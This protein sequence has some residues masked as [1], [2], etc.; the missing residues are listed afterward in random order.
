[1]QL[2]AARQA[3][4]AVM[5]VYCHIG[6]VVLPGNDA[7]D[8]ED[9]DDGLPGGREEGDYRRTHVPAPRRAS[10]TTIGHT[11][12]L[13]SEPLRRRKSR[14]RLSLTRL[15]VV[16]PGRRHGIRSAE[17][18]GP[19]GAGRLTPCPGWTRNQGWVPKKA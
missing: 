5:L 16:G 1:M 12:Q 7:E 9:D 6:S 18:T 10:A 3:G 13:A 14:C 4:Y 17:L 15:Q 8:D 19:P 2:A 11:F